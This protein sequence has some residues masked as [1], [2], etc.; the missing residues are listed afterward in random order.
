M[1]DVSDVTQDFAIAAWHEDAEI[2]FYPVINSIDIYGN[3]SHKNEMH[4]CNIGASSCYKT[5]DT[6]PYEKY[7]QT[8]IKVKAKRLDNVLK[9]LNIEE[10]H[11]KELKDFIMDTFNVGKHAN[12]PYLNYSEI[13]KGLISENKFGRKLW[14]LLSL[15]LWFQNFYDKQAEFKKFLASE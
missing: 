11:K 4:K 1:G 5:N 3:V 10:H 15:E 14:G 7:T 6:W 8:E 13:E 9:N 2:S 12:R